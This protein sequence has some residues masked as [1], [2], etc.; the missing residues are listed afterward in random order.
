MEL[1]LV[2]TRMPPALS[3]LGS[4]E[5]HFNLSVI[6]RARSKDSVHTP[7]VTEDT[8]ELKLNRT[9]VLVLPA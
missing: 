1:E 5:S 7:Q 9:E 8:G 6:L 3:Y 4:D 2:T